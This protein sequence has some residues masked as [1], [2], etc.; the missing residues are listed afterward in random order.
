MQKP[1]FEASITYIGKELDRDKM[2]IERLLSASSKPKVNKELIPSGQD[3]L[4]KM[5]ESGW[6]S[7]DN[8]D[9]LYGLLEEINCCD[10]VHKAKLE[11]L[12]YGMFTFQSIIK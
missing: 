2:L 12:I 5:Q 4:T 7:P 11:G 10:I 3:L 8:P 9:P 6:I 1:N